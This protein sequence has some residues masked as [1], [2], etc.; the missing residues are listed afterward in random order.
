MGIEN[1]PKRKINDMQG[2][3]WHC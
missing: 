3:G 2:Y 1:T